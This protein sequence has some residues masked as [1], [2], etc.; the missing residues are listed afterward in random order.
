MSQIFTRKSSVK[1]YCLSDLH[2]DTE[3]NQKYVRDNC[4]KKEE[5]EDAFTVFIVPG[6]IGSEV[7]RIETV[8]KV[9]VENYDAVC[10]VPGNHEAWRRGTLSGGSATNPSLRADSRMAPDSV[11]KLKE[12]IYV[13][14]RCGVYTGPLRVV[15]GASSESKFVYQT[16]TENDNGG[17]LIMPL[18]SWYHSSW[19]TEPVLTDQ[20]FLDVEEAIPFK[21][22]WGD[23]NLCSWPEQLVTQEEFASIE[24]KSTALAESFAQLNEPFLHP[25]GEGIEA[26]QE[27]L[28][29]P[30]CRS[31]DT[32]I[33]FSHFL[34][35]QELCPEKRFMIEPFL[36][37]VVGSDVLE[38]QVR[39]LQPHVHLF[40]HTHIPIDLE[41]DG[42]RYVQWP[43]GYRK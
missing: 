22:K 1:C 20:L 21:T 11:A 19:D 37:R 33:S 6:D 7:D 10:Y 25:P 42:I 31:G 18:Y 38:S 9:L 40:G 41:L 17:T 34:P 16:L 15:P 36:S 14:N 35:R 28:G 39:R 2:A 30:L 13:A 29:S 4:V 8:L 24:S 27:S 12:I 26:V 23:F 5:D 32:I 3:N 43:L